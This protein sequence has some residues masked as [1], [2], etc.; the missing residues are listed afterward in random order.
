MH[1]KPLGLL[2]KKFLLPRYRELIM[3]LYALMK[4]RTL[5]YL[6]NRLNG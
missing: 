1:M 2:E 5:P 6:T 4:I 3:N